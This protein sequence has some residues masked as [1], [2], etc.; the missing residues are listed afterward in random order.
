MCIAG[1]TAVH[2]FMEE[3]TGGSV[4]AASSAKPSDAAS[5]AAE[6]ERTV[7]K[8]TEF[9]TST[10]VENKVE[11]PQE[12]SVSVPK[13]APADL[14]SAKAS[15]SNGDDSEINTVSRFSLLPD[16][17]TVPTLT[18]NV[19]KASERYSFAKKLRAKRG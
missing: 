1:F 13:Q 19:S 16:N 3:T 7:E 11:L 12:D 2:D 17:K 10:S 8:G 18:A 9:S 14:Q 6:G 4:M 15:V 5:W